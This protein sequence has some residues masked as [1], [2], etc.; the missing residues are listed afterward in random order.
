MGKIQKVEDLKANGRNPR[1]ISDEKLQSLRH[2]LNEFGDLSGFVFNRKSGQLVGGHQRAKAIP[3]D[4]KIKIVREYSPPTDKGTVAIG[5]VLYRG[6]RFA[7]REVSWAKGKE[8]A[9]NLA[10]N[11]GAGEWDRD[12]LGEMMKDID[13]EGFDLDFTMFDEAERAEFFSVDLEAHEKS[14]SENKWPEKPPERVSSGDLF[15]LGDHRLICGDAT[16]AATLKKLFGTDRA[17]MVFTSPPY[18]G[19]TTLTY[20]ARG[21]RGLY[22]DNEADDRTS[23]EYLEFNRQ[24]FDGFKKFLKLDANVFYNINYN[25]KSR[26]EWLRVALQA[27]D[28]GWNLFETIV[29][30]KNGIPISAPDVMTRNFEFIFLFNQGETYRTNKEQANQPGGGGFTS[31]FWDIPV[32]NQGTTQTSDH[33]ACFP[34]A[35]PE[36]ALMENSVE[37]D[38]VFEPFA[39]TGTTLIAADKTGRR[40]YGVEL[41]PKYCDGILARWEEFSGK[42]AKRA[43]FKSKKEK[44]A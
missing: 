10:A 20:G 26:D 19:A 30:R 35:L 18:N 3:T 33:G 13:A 41:D 31:N 16:D 9:A 1:R 29:W 34:V 21:T 32:N 5:Y 40:C 22:S 27:I 39:G 23:E 4:A 28:G 43:V 15:L 6:E 44:A 42:V 25:K 36:K 8:Y 14:E 38:L 2:S 7:Y 24:V 17:D 37:G 12:L 11:K